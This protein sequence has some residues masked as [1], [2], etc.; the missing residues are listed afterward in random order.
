MP[1]WYYFHDPD[2]ELLTFQITEDTV[3]YCVDC[4][5]DFVSPQ[6]ESTPFPYTNDPKIFMQYLD[7]SSDGGANNPFLLIWMETQ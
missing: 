1:N 5:R 4:G 7:T 6:G 3:F 2:H